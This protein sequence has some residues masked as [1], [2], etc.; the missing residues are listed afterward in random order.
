MP[1]Q[2]LIERIEDGLRPLAVAANEASWDANVDSTEETERAKVRAEVAL[3]DFL[4]DPLLLEHVE[5]GLANDVTADGRRALGVVRD[6]A[7]PHQIPAALRRRIVELEASVEARYVQH[8]GVLHGHEVSDNEIRRVLRT[9]DDQRERRDAWL[10]SKTVGFEVADDVRQLARLRNEAAR[11][12]GYRDWFALAIDTMEMTETRLAETLGEADRLTAEPFRAWK[13]S[14]DAS[15]GTRFGVSSGELRPW[16]YD[17]PFFQ[18]VPRAASVD[19]D[20]LLRGSDIVALARR[21]FLGLGLETQP[22]IARSDL[23]P[24]DGKCQHAFCLH[25]DRA[26][27]IRVLCNIEANK[28]WMD[29]T[30]HELGHAVYDASI[31]HDL[32]WLFRDCH[33]T[34][35]EG[36]ALLSGSL[37]EDADWLVRIVGMSQADADA[38]ARPLAASRAVDLLV[39][40]RWVL[41]IT[42]FERELYRDPDGDLDA[43]WW[44]LVHRY[45]RLTPPA[46]RRAPDWAA[47]IHIACSPVYYHTYLYG[48]I[49]GSQLRDALAREAGG[50]VERPDAGRF[51]VERLFRPGLSLRWDQLVEHATGEPLTARFF[52]SDIQ[53]GLA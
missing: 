26:G 6:W 34:T 17:D 30:L 53:R 40:T 15:L 4:G 28:E 16:H 52:A 3:T 12:W 19:L 49:V 21:T 1:G 22:I 9:S 27:D 50:F 38:L 7:L 46:D 32:P 42:A 41:V 45:Q 14:Y 20:E 44:E 48:K 31:D 18:D 11:L 25:V 10:A 43:I 33:L 8:R 24:R 35:T 37:V 13:A 36:M 51:L 47:K 2:A 23:F 29:T 5:A 39:F